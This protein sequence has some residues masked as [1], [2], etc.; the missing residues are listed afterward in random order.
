MHLLLVVG[1]LEGPPGLCVLNYVL[2]MFPAAHVS[3]SRD[4]HVA[5]GPQIL[6]VFGVRGFTD[7]VVGF[8]VGAQVEAHH[9]LIF[10]ILRIFSTA[11]NYFGCL[12]G[13]YETALHRILLIDVDQDSLRILFLRLQSCVNNLGAIW[14]KTRKMLTNSTL[15]ILSRRMIIRELV[16][17]LEGL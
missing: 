4:V 8:D 17:S 13:R 9:V 16:D 11:R 12:L 2:Q 5:S 10:G 14:L 6:I 1:V 7:S 3:K 15:L